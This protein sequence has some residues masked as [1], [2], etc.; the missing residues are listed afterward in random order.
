MKGF[1]SGTGWPANCWDGSANGELVRRWLRWSVNGWD[2]SV[3]GRDGNLMVG[4][5]R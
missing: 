1:L 5:I 4:T 3:H 2:G